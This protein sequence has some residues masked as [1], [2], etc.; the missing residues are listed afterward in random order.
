MFSKYVGRPSRRWQIRRLLPI[1]AGLLL[2][3]GGLAGPTS[4]QAA[5]AAPVELVLPSPASQ[6]SR[7]WIIHAPVGP[8]GPL[9]ERLSASLGVNVQLVRPMLQPGSVLV[10]MDRL[11]LLGS[12]QN[13]AAISALLNAVPGVVFAAPDALLQ[14]SD[15]PS[16]PLYLSNQASYLRSGQYASLNMEAVWS[17]TRGSSNVVIAVLDSGVLPDHPELRGRLLPGYDFVAEVSPPTGTRETGTVRITGSNDGNGRDADPSDPGDAPP[18]GFTCPGGVV[19][20][21]FHGTAVA[22]VAVAQANNGFAGAG[23]DWNAKVLPVR[24][25]G[26][27]GIATTADIVDAFYWAAGTGRVDPAIGPNPNPAQVINLSFASDTPLLGGG[28]GDAGAAPVRRAIADARAAG[29][30]VVISAGNNNGGAVQFPASCPGAIAAVAVQHDGVLASYSAR[31]SSGSALTLAAPGNANGGYVGASN[32]GFGSGPQRGAPNPQA[33]GAAVFFGTSF[34]APMVA[35]AV[36]LLKAA[37]PSLSPEQMVALLRNNARPFPP[38]ANR[39]GGLLFG[40]RA[41]NCT[42]TSCASGILDPAAALDAVRAQN[43]A[44]LAN[45]PHSRLTAGAATTV[46]DGSLST[47]ALGR[48][49]GLTYRWRQVLGNPVPVAA[50]D[51][52][53]LRVNSALAGGLA[54]FELTVTDARTNQTSAS[55]VRLVGNGVNELTFVPPLTTPPA[56]TAGPDTGGA[57]PTQPS[58]APSMPVAASGGGGGGLLGVVGLLGLFGL[59]FARRRAV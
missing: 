40:V 12:L 54:E 2:G 1:A 29:A 22:S 41:C 34:S 13:N 36:S 51:G 17:Q 4:A 14:R 11:P 18:P 15:A 9:L 49:E 3:L 37:N 20:S 33:H 32:P 30:T 58:E 39:C 50:A 53:E 48:S 26:R 19:A 16:D 38:G 43:A 46:L 24:V 23:M 44:P 8:L 25:S 28:C 42:A 56:Q 57:T 59:L 5:Q 21:S 6:V 7:Q 55:S 10:Q 45:T 35:G 52:P 27:C 31:G 47:N